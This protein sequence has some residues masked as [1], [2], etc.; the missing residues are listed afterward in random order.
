MI[1]TLNIKLLMGHFAEADWDVTIA[2]DA[3]STLE[4]L[5]DMIQQAVDFDNDHL[6]SFY[7]ARTPRSGEHVLYDQEEPERL[8]WEVTLESLFPLPKDRRLYY[9]FDYG[10]HWLFQIS[11]TRKKPFAPEPGD[12]YPVLI[13]EHGDKPQQYPDPDYTIS[14]P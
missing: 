1:W 11:R 7:V 8:P 14:F 2:L 5:H 10:D 6:Y 3:A 13:S 9:L 12:D 4:D